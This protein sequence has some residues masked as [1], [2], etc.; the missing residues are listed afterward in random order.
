MATLFS[1]SLV[2]L[3]KAAGF[4]TAYRFF[5]D[6]GGKHVLGAS[7]R[8]Y[9]LWEQGKALPPVPSLARL[10]PA[11]KLLPKSVPLGGLVAAWLKTMA[12]EEFYDEVLKPFVSV[13]ENTPGL[14]PL[15]KAMDRALNDKKYP[16][17]VE[18]A[19]SILSTLEHYKAFLFM[20][21]DTGAWSDTAFAGGIGIGKPAAARVIRDFARLG[22]LKKTKGGLFQCPLTDRMLEFPRAE[23]MPAGYGDRMEKYQEE[24]LASGVSAWHRLG[25]VRADGRDFA[26][27]YPMM[28]LNMSTAQTYAITEK[29]EHSAMFAVEGRI[30]KLRDF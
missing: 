22:L 7:Y 10:V 21:N 25:F 28:S 19:T 14:S 8:Q 5:H 9:L 27:F 13:K 3:R 30:V 29:T 18:Q 11:L 1:V 15:H 17:S 12:G 26:A 24:L 6:N 23:I 2:Q 4:P 20:I 16:L